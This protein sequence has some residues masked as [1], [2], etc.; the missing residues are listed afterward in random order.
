MHGV[1]TA[2]VA[3]GGGGGHISRQENLNGHKDFVVVESGGDNEPEG[4]APDVDAEQ[5]GVRVTDVELDG[6]IAA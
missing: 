2:D 5:R 6:K 1:R 3:G 4:C